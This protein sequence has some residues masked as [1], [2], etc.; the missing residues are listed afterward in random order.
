M[1]EQNK[2]FYTVAEIITGLR[3]DY[4]ILRERLLKL[5]DLLVVTADKE[6]STT[7]YFNY[8]A[9]Y[10]DLDALGVY[11]KVQESD[12]LYEAWQ[13]YLAKYFYHDF[14]KETALYH[15]K[16]INGRLMFI[17]E[18]E[19][20]VRH[21]YIKRVGFSDDDLAKQT[22]NNLK[23]VPFFA[24]PSVRVDLNVYQSLVI[25]GAF[26]Y[27]HNEDSRNG[28]I[29]IIYDALTDEIRVNSST[30]CYPYFLERLLATEVYK[31]QIP[32]KLRTLIDNSNNGQRKIAI[33][34]N[35]KYRKESFGFDYN[36][37]KKLVLAK[38][39]RQRKG[40]V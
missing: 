10:Q 33:E 25:D 29:D 20:F 3:S 5:Q 22:Y 38:K 1:R 40:E 39:T 37:Q 26:I 30:N 17:D 12:K 13:K 2:D 14:Q 34:D 31:G 27:F 16:E 9:D 4:V 18:T 36:Y 28:V 32:V 15:L 8:M 7:L 11:A 21:D 6:V 24:I 35:I 19:G 23:Q